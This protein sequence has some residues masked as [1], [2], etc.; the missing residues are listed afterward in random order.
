VFNYDG[1]ALFYGVEGQKTLVVV[2][3][4][5]DILSHILSNIQQCSIGFKMQVLQQNGGNT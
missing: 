5:L 1:V 2:H 4:I 3:L